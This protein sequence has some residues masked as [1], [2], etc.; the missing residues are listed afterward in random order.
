MAIRV[1]HTT[2]ARTERGLTIAERD[3]IDE[4]ISAMTRD[5]QRRVLHNIDPDLLIE[6]ANEK[7]REF[8]E[9]VNDIRKIVINY[10]NKSWDLVTLWNETKEYEKTI[11]EARYRK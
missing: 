7:T 5:Q 2:T 9:F 1:S 11:K 8:A 10:Q 4:V 6:A 3:K